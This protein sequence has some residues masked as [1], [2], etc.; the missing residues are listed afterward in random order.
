[1]RFRRLKKSGRAKPSRVT[2]A[3][4]SLCR[5]LSPIVRIVAEAGGPGRQRSGQ[6]ADTGVTNLLVLLLQPPVQAADSR[7]AS[8]QSTDRRHELENSVQK[9]Q[10]PVKTD[11]NDGDAT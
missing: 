9:H 2:G 7:V 4:P 8:L 1:M 5:W 6:P 3:E 10:N 11:G